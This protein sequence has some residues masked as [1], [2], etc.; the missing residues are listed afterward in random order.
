MTAA[1][2]AW[3]A[4]HNVALANL[5]QVENQLR[6]YNVS[7]INNMPADVSV[8]ASILDDFPVRDVALSGVPRGDGF[9]D[10]SWE[11]RVAVGVI[12]FVEDFLFSGGTVVSAPVTI[13][14][15]R[16]VRG[17]TFVRKNAIIEL[18]SKGQDTLEYFYKRG[19]ARVRYVFH[20]LTDPS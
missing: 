9:V 17:N 2:Y 16:H 4:G 8:I 18:P 5:I 1:L 20:N 13:Y 6:P 10:C 14:T 19:V 7:S 11:M 3:A 12:A 15:R